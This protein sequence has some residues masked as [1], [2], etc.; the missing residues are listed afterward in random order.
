MPDIRSIGGGSFRDGLWVDDPHIGSSCNSHR[1]D[2]HCIHGGDG[3]CCSSNLTGVAIHKR[4][5]M[6]KQQ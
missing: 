1:T 3:K 2:G 4:Y 6:L 5:D